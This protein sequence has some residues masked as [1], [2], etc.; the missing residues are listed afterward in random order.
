MAS[1]QSLVNYQARCLNDSLYRN[2]RND[3]T[4]LNNADQIGCKLSVP[5]YESTQSG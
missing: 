1:T 2:F 5:L 3:R 4:G